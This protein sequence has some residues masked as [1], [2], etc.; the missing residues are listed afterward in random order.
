MYR[1]YPP[2]SGLEHIKRTGKY[3][4]ILKQVTN[5]DENSVKEKSPED[6]KRDSKSDL[7]DVMGFDL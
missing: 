5:I 2:E 7:L 4:A 1:H 3:P 6:V